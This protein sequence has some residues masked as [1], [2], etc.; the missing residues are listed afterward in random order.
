MRSIARIAAAAALAGAAVLAAA[1]AAGADEGGGRIDWPSPRPPGRRAGA[2]PG[3]AGRPAAHR[4][5]VTGRREPVCAAPAA[6]AADA[7]TRAPAPARR[8]VMEGG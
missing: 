4:L 3:G 5:A 2:R 7:P 8:A 6:R 1:G